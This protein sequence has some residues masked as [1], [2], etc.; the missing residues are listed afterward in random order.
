MRG[1]TGESELLWSWAAEK[2]V[3]CGDCVPAAAPDLHPRLRPL[4]ALCLEQNRGYDGTIRNALDDMCKQEAL[5]DT[6]FLK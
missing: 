1:P 6:A 3:H 4:P 5:K 2:L